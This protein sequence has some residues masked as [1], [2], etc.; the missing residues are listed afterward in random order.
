[1]LTSGGLGRC[2]PVWAGPTDNKVIPQSD[3][4]AD[5]DGVDTD[6]SGLLALF[7][8]LLLDS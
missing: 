3:A 5:P 4:I 1:L 8:S 2:S 6:G 7:G